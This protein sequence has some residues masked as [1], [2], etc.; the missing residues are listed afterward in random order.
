[1][2]TIVSGAIPTEWYTVAKRSVGWT[3]LSSGAEAV[4]SDL[5]YTNPRFTPAPA[6]TAV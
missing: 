5:P 4:L 6:T 3:G 1:L 2:Y